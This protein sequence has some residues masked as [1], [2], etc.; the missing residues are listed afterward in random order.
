MLTFDLT[1]FPLGILNSPG[2]CT[3]I[4]KLRVPILLGRFSSLT[5]SWG[6]CCD[7]KQTEPTRMIGVFLAFSI[8]LVSVILF[9]FRPPRLTAPGPPAFP[10]IGSPALKIHR[11]Y[12]R[13]KT[14]VELTRIY[15]PVVHL[16]MPFTMQSMYIIADP[17]LA[18]AMLTDKEHFFGRPPNL[19]LRQIM[20]SGLLGL[21]DGETW[22]A[23]RRVMTAPL[24]NREHIDEYMIIISECLKTFVS[25]LEQE[26]AVN[27]GGGVVNVAKHLKS[28]TLDAILRLAF[29]FSDEKFIEA[30]SMLGTLD[31]DL[32]FGA[33]FKANAPALLWKILPLKNK[34]NRVLGFLHHLVDQ[35]IE[36]G[37]AP[38]G[39][40]IEAL[41]L[42]T[43]PESKVRLTPTELKDESLG[44]LLAGHE[45]LT[46]TLGWTLYLLS[47]PEN[48]KA[49]NTLVNEIDLRLGRQK[50]TMTS[51]DFDQMTYCQAVIM[52]ALRMYPTVPFFGRYAANGGKLGGY[53]ILPKSIVF[54]SN[55]GI[56]SDEKYFP[57]QDKFLPERH[58]AVDS[59]AGQSPTDLR[60]KDFFPFGG[61]HRICIGKR[62][63]QVEAVMV[64]SKLLQHFKLESSEGF[65]PDVF[66]TITLASKNGI[67]VKLSKRLD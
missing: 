46:N 32:L 11:L 24:F 27:Q 40:I 33:A 25:S 26:I 45:T 51:A 16:V 6:T 43:D 66:T 7:T 23:H 58:I 19:P 31:Q 67:S 3:F 41:K 35:V 42:A 48:S 21:S 52:E 60:K 44:I 22:K 14:H 38:K 18:R 50:D 2:A 13:H 30:S 8:V 64:L 55:L 17:E 12:H 63:A 39:S 20:P 47:R 5:L 49:L 53:E 57:E 61:G 65:E 62:L 15:G 36:E 37:K 54:I 4:I 10:L 9:W 34:F 1:S 56:T 28:V 59:G 29:G